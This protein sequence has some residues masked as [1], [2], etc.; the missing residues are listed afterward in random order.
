MRWIRWTV[1]ILA[2]VAVALA[3]AAVSQAGAS[4]RSADARARATMRTFS[5]V[6]Y[7][8]TRSL[9]V[10][11]SG[12]ASESVGDG[13]CDPIIDVRM[14]LSRVTGTNKK[15][16][17]RAL[18]TYVKVHD[19]S[20]FGSSHP[21]PHVGEVKRL[22]LNHGILHEPFTDQIYCGSKAPAGACGA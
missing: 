1:T 14:R 10:H 20:A 17:V 13:C 21:A 15:A 9:T 7:G 12:K 11:R 3:V 2:V 5:G 6:W 18:V 4:H 19:A 16:T 22:R 8:H